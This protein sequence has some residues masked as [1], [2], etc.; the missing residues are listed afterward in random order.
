MAHT[1]GPWFV[2]GNG[3][4]VGGPHPENETAGIAMCSMRL[5]ESL[6][7]KW[8]ARLIATAPDLIATLRKIAE[9]EGDSDQQEFKLTRFQCAQLARQ[10]IYRA[11]GG[12]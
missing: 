8:N 11:T 4:C 1:P 12:N 10:A 2:F 9:A 6:E 3:Y 7:N 5:R